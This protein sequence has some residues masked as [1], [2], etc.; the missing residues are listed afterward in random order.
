LSA[1]DTSY[2]GF[3]NHNVVFSHLNLKNMSTTMP[4]KTGSEKKIGKKLVQAGFE[5]VHAFD[6]AW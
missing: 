1:V 5:L 2:C 4:S 3:A 6:T